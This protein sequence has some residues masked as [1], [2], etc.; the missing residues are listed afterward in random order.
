MI[1]GDTNI[2]IKKNS[3]E[4]SPVVCNQLLPQMQ[5]KNPKEAS[6][7]GYGTVAVV[8]SLLVDISRR[9]VRVRVAHGNLRP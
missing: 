9:G 7:D 6:N 3:S 4:G 1:N 8:H 2:Y 5:L